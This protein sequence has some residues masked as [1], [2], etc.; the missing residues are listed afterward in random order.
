MKNVRYNLRLISQ[1]PSKKKKNVSQT[2]NP[3]YNILTILYPAWLKLTFAKILNPL[4]TWETLAQCATECTDNRSS[5]LAFQ[6]RPYTNIALYPRKQW[7][8][9]LMLF[10]MLPPR[11]DSRN[12]W[13]IVVVSGD[14]GMHVKPAFV[15]LLDPCTRRRRFVRY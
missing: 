6:H 2:W 5:W 13:T 11:F 12:L 15:C 3:F 7:K 8:C 14:N 10:F 4:P 9:F 1:P